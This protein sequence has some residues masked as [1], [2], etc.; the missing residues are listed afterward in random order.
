MTSSVEVA[1]LRGPNRTEGEPAVS[2]YVYLRCEDHDPPLTSDGESGQHLYDLDQIRADIANRDAV[3]AA[4]R[5]DLTSQDSFRRST[6]RFLAEH[7]K[8]QIGIIDEYRRVHPLTEKPE[9]P[10]GLGAVVVDER[11][12]RWVRVESAK[13]MWNP[14]QATLHAAEPDAIRSLSYAAIAAVEVLSDGVT[15]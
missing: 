3:A 4:W 10:L 15:P 8:C 7:P 11:G 2:T 5:D 1:H 13:G 9:E 6:A 12:V 14:W